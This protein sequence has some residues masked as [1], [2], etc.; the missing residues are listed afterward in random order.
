M[1]DKNQNHRIKKM[2][3]LPGKKAMFFVIEDSSNPNYITLNG[4]EMLKVQFEHEYQGYKI[5]SMVRLS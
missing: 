2:V 1:D 4:K 3:Q 5:I